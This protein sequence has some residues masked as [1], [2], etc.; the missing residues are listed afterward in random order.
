VNIA[1]APAIASALTLRGGTALLGNFPVTLWIQNTNNNTSTARSISVS[2]MN[3]GT[4]LATTTNTTPANALIN[5]VSFVLNLPTN[6]MLPAG[7]SL[8]L[9][10]A[11]QAGSGRNIAITP[12]STTYSRVDLNSLTV[13]NV[14]SVQSYNATYAGG[15]VTG[16][17]NRGATMYV[18]AVVSD[19][20]GSF[21]ISSASITLRNPANADVITVAMTQVN[22]SGAALKTY[23]YAY[24]LPSNAPAGGWT[25]RVTA[26]EGDEGTIT[27]LG[28]GTFTV[29]VPMPTLQVSKISDIVS[30]PVSNTTNPKRI[31]GSVIR[32]TITVTNTGPGTVDASTL[33][34]TDAVPANTTLCVAASCGGVVQFVDGTPASGLSFNYATQVSYSTAAAGVAPFDHTASPDANGFDAA[35][36]G[37]RIAPI[38][39]MSAAGAGSPNFS[40]RF[41]VKVN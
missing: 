27:D 41:Y 7:S 33:V 22:D 4:V 6:T 30:D 9:R 31:P 15:A 14:D 23:E 34:M 39:A 19:P 38:G 16:S 1:I 20:F 35:I 24:T 10:I 5:A 12:F 2:L 17:F 21:D 8:T 40:I 36:T 32:Y 26:N 18:R 29:T 3:G 13:I 25:A 11:N 37:I 28:I